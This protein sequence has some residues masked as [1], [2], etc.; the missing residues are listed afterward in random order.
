MSL[1]LNLWGW[2]MGPKLSSKYIA[3]ALDTMYCISRAEAAESSKPPSGGESGARSIT[4]DAVIAAAIAAVSLTVLWL[5][6]ALAT[7][8]TPVPPFSSCK[9]PRGNSSERRLVGKTSADRNFQ[10]GGES[11]H[12]HQQTG[13][14]PPRPGGTRRHSSGARPANRLITARRYIKHP[15]AHLQSEMCPYGLTHGPRNG[16]GFSALARCCGDGYLRSPGVTCGRD[17]FSQKA[18][19]WQRLEPPPA[20]N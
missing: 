17:Q 1:S 10:S 14:P 19:A 12:A 3:P 8:P 9:N 7:T 20:L 16:D 15:L 11:R 6:T 2:K 4:G 5:L 13:S 18:A